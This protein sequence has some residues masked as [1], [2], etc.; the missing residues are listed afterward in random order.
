MHLLFNNFN[1][2]FCARINIINADFIN[3]MGTLHNS[4]DLTFNAAHGK[5]KACT[6][7]PSSQAFLDSMYATM[8]SKT[9]D[10]DIN[11]YQT[12]LQVLQAQL[13]TARMIAE[14]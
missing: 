9:A 7:D 13:L 3:K 8:R 6:A 10:Y 2:L 4:H 1:S 11:Y 14:Q 12:S 5:A